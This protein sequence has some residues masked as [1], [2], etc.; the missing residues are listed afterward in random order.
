[1]S[2]RPGTTERKTDSQPHPGLIALLVFVLCLGC[3]LSNGRT[4]PLQVGGDT[5]PNRLVP[6]SILGFGTLS[7]D[8]FREDFAAAGHRHWYAQERGGHLVSLYPIGTSL[9][10]LPFYV[11]VY[12]YLRATGRADHASLFEYSEKAEKIAASAMAALSVA[13]FYLTARRRVAHR[14]AF[15]SSVAFGLGTSVWAT[16]SQMLWQHGAVVLTLTLALLFLTWRERPYWSAAGAGFALALGLI[17]RPTVTALYLAGLGCQILIPGPVRAK[18]LRGVL[19]VVGSAPVLIFDLI[20]G[21]D[22]YNSSLGGYTAL[23]L[24]FF[25][26]SKFLL[27][28]GGVLVSPNR[29]LFVFTPIALLGFYG[30]VR[31]S[32]R[33]LRERDPLMPMFGLAIAVHLFAVASYSE[34]GGGWVFGTRYLVDILPVLGLSAAEAW[35]SLPRFGKR[36]TAVALVWSILVQLNGAFCYPASQWN[37]RAEGQIE[38]QA[39]NPY[40]FE[41]WEDFRAWLTLDG[42]AAP[43]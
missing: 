25:V 39:W 30:F 29:G 23:Q 17:T 2:E 6:F 4:L 8:P 11:P 33:S 34:W 27:G 14:T 38:R 26:P 37:K 22:F 20:F 21:G 31:G 9:V 19:F 43:Y 18:L 7:L 5:I 1:M 13:V 24:G 32:L 36:L 10:A 16:A 40:R 42:V 3:Y 35:S 12:L 41:L 15:W 28:L